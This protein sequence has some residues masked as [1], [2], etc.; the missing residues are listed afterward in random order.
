MLKY[1]KGQGALEYLLVIGG[2]VLI[3]VTVVALIIGLGT[4]TRETTK[5]QS[6]VVQQGTDMTV[7]AQIVSVQKDSLMC[8]SNNGHDIDINVSWR[9]MGVGGTHYIRLID[10]SGSPVNFTSPGLTTSL[11]PN[12]LNVNVKGIFICPVGVECPLKCK[13]TYYVYIETKKNNQTV[14]S[15]KYRFNWR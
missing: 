14:E 4:Q 7:P 11:D 2:A 13:D 10:S 5:E 15:Q 3:A 1:N 12:E 9:P 6:D 8:E